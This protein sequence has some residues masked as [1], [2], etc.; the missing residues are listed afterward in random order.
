[1]VTIILLIILAKN[2]SLF[3]QPNNKRGGAEHWPLLVRRE[4]PSRG[5]GKGKEE[6][7]AGSIVGGLALTSLLLLLL[8]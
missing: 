6:A 4:T 2:A 3:P 1:M 7:K 8:L 5:E